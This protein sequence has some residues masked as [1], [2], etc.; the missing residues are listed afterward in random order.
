ML[1]IWH[2]QDLQHL[3]PLFR[4]RY[5]MNP[6]I[7]LGKQFDIS[8][9]ALILIYRIQG[10]LIVVTQKNRRSESGRF[11]VHGAKIAYIQRC[12]LLP[13]SIPAH[14]GLS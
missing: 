13:F 5:E 10:D 9:S 4:H 11:T 8:G 7:V 1:P 14:Y 2:Y 12:L 6:V 3:S